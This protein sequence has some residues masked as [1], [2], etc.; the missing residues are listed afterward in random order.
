M[1]MELYF[2]I[3]L[4]IIIVALVYMNYSLDIQVKSLKSGYQDLVNQQDKAAFEM[5]YL[6]TRMSQNMNNIRTIIKDEVT[7]LQMDVSCIEDE[8]E[9]LLVLRPLARK[10]ELKKQLKNYKQDYNF[11]KTELKVINDELKDFA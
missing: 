4:F 10:F 3:G 6:D 8:V 7:S 5:R 9:S 1:T 2:I 11:V